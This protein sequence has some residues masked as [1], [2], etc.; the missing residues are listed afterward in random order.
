MES[1]SRCWTRWWPPWFTSGPAPC[2]SS[3]TSPPRTASSCSKSTATPPALLTTTS[4]ERR[5]HRRG[6][7]NAA[8]VADVPL[9]EQ[10][11][12]FYGAGAA[13]Q[14]VAD[15][16]KAAMVGAGV[17]EAQARSAFYFVDSKGLVTTTR[18]DRLPAYKVAY[19]RTD[20][21]PIASLRQIIRTVRP[22][23]LIGLSAVPNAFSKDV[24]V[25]MAKLNRRPIIFAL[26]NPTSKSELAAEK[27]IKWTQGRVV[28]AA[29]SPYAPVNRRPL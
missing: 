27:A 26:S 18:G 9:G 29:G 20:L 17:P 13:G 1:T 12:V 16:I 4:R 15:A 21:P 8:A 28:Y 25:E 6:F 11:I 5:R 23:A 14:G 22:T 10:R 3:R 7:V 24:V 2:C 19:A